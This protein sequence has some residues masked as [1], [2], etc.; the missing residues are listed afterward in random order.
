[1]KRKL[2]ISAFIFIPL[3]LTTTACGNHPN[4][5]GNHP[6]ISGSQPTVET[7]DKNTS[8]S[9]EK[10]I[11]SEVGLVYTHTKT[12]IEWASEEIKKTQLDEMGIDEKIFFNIYD[13]ALLEF[14]FLEDSKAVV[15]Y[16]MQGDGGAANVL[17]K[18]DNQTISFYDSLEDMQANK[19]KDVAVFA[20]QFKLSEDYQSLY[21][22]VHQEGLLAITLTCT[23]K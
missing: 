11:E 22:M 13:N 3:F 5:S 8:S 14:R 23:I 9:E 21:W 15:I 10:P 2:F 6:N 18:I 17:Y 4:I 1:M 16:E 12:N 7:T 19:T 20:G